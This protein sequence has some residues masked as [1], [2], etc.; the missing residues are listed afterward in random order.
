[1]KWTLICLTFKSIKQQNEHR[2]LVLRALPDLSFDIRRQTA[3]YR[4]RKT[5]KPQVLNASAIITLAFAPPAF[6]SDYWRYTPGSEF[7]M[8]SKTCFIETNLGSATRLGNRT[9]WEERHACLEDGKPKEFGDPFTG[10]ANCSTQM[11]LVN[12][13]GYTDWIT[14][15]EARKDTHGYGMGHYGWGLACGATGG[16]N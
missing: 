3:A 12:N 6:G 9:M 15:D 8:G 10:V 14:F 16:F 4:D 11:L 5:L 7:D 1:M 2:E 13:H